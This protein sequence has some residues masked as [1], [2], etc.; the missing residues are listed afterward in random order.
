[1]PGWG[2]LELLL[3]LKHNSLVHIRRSLNWLSEL[4]MRR[5]RFELSPEHGVLMANTLG[6]GRFGVQLQ[7]HLSPEPLYVVQ[8]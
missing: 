2:N 8:F 5:F 3:W 6:S 7:L 1:M 4:N